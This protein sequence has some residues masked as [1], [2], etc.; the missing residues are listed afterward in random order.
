MD[1]DAEPQEHQ[2]QPL[3]VQRDDHV[4]SCDVSL[5]ETRDPRLGWP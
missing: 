2:T 5:I 3:A 4:D 1:G